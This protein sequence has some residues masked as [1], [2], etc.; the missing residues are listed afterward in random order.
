M[1]LYKEVIVLGSLT[2]DSGSP[3]APAVSGSIAKLL[4]TTHCLPQTLA[5]Q[6]T[7]THPSKT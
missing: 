1:G 3:K 6:K 5:T 2:L 4:T 7:P